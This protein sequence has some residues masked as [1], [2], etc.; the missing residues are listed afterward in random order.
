MFDLDLLPSGEIRF[1]RGNSFTNE[2]LFSFLK[3]IGIKDINEIKQF[4]DGS[5]KIEKI[6]G[7]ESFCG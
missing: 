7:K 4:F 1:R 5:N 2:Q 6:F 3:E